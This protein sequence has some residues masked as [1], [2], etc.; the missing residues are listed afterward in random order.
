VRSVGP[1]LDPAFGLEVLFDRLRRAALSFYS[2]G[3]AVPFALCCLAL[4][5]SLKLIKRMARFLPIIERHRICLLAMGLLLL[6][7][8]SPDFL[9]GARS[10][11]GWSH[12]LNSLGL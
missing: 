3:L 8:S 6:T 7:A 11:H 4:E 12:A 1:W 5:Q 2:L 10:L 9:L